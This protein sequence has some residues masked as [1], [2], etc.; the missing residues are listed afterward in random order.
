MRNI[1]NTLSAIGALTLAATPL[2]AVGGLARAAEPA[3]QPA[4]VQVSDLDL[5]RASDAATFRSRVDAA[6]DA[7]CSQEAVHAPRAACVDAV[8]EEAVEKLGA[9]QRRDLQAAQARGSAAWAVA[10]R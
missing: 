8:R 9:A 10:A 4:Y 1:L 5:S 3:V 6:A 7:V 2:L